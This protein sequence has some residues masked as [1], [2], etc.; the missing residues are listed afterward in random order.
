MATLQQ[1]YVNLI[2]GVFVGSFSLG[3]F[4]LAVRYG[5]NNEIAPRSW[6]RPMAILKNTLKAPYAFSW[7]TLSLK[8]SYPDLMLGIPGTGTRKDGWAGPT[9]KVNLDGI[10]MLKYHVMLVKIALL[11]TVL[12]IFVIL[13]INYTAQCEIAQ[14]GNGT[15]ATLSNLTDFERTTIANIPPL[16]YNGTNA[17][18]D[19]QDGYWYTSLSPRYFA[20]SA[21]ALIIYWYICRKSSPVYG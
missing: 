6:S 5:Y 10:I 3:L 18:Q 20:I 8:W 14:L 4:G 11:A 12:C 16:Q 7:M 15:C 19:D 21:I 13:P 9:L 1:I 2:S 17:Q